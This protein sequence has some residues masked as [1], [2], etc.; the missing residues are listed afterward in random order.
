[1]S[2]GVVVL[3]DNPVRSYSWGS[4][5]VLPRLLGR[6]PTGEPQAELWV[7]AHP[8]A[9]SRV[10]GDGRTLDAYIAADPEAALG[11][12]NVARFGPRLP[13]LLKILA[14]EQPLSIQAHP[15]VAQAVDGYAADDAAGIPLDAPNRSYRDRN[16]K[17]E[18]VVA[19]SDFEALIGFAPPGETARILDS[20]GGELRTEAD[21]LRADG[22]ESLVRRWLTLPADDAGALVETV[23]AAASRHDRPW[24][25]LLARLAKAYPG[26]R[27]LLVALTL[28]EVRL[29]PG[30]AAFV[31]AGVP[32]AYLSGVA[33]EPQASSDNTLRAGLTTKHVNTAELLRILRYETGGVVLTRPQGPPALQA[34]PVPVADFRLS[35]LELSSGDVTLTEGPTTI[36]VVQG[37]ATVRAAGEAVVVMPGEAAFVPAAEGTATVTG[38]GLAFA[39]APGADAAG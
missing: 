37:S 4:S 26:D 3:L 20:I 6:E 24:A 19:L 18:M 30:E 11:A 12:V 15:T 8:G 29:R 1:M 39:I 10:V 16:H 36:L 34:Y 35:R 14:V 32:H 31:G 27:G 33:V 5:T 28:Q 23:T 38:A 7:G 17:P 25:E 22:I 13:Y 21:R 2:A 9:P